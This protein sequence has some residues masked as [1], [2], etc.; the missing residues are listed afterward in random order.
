MGGS[1]S[2]PNFSDP[3]DLF[4]QVFGSDFAVGPT[5]G[6]GQRPN[7]EMANGNGMFSSFLGGSMPTINTA[8][9]CG[10]FTSFTYS[11]STSTGGAGPG[12]LMQSVS[13]TTTI[14][15]GKKVTRT[16]RTTIN[17]DGTRRT[18]VDLTGNDDTDDH[19]SSVPRLMEGEKTKAPQASASKQP[20]PKPAHTSPHRTHTGPT[21][22]NSAKLRGVSNVA[23]PP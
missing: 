1:A 19:Q 4:R 13:T 15:N 10:N 6:T 7:E 3:F 16:E 8:Q 11:S 20:E 17:P 14:E 2:G 22:A 9:G 12:G 5:H 18:V 21:S 23:F